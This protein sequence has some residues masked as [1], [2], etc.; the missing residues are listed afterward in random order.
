MNTMP[1]EPDSF[2]SDIRK[3]LDEV[4][5]ISDA[6]GRLPDQIAEIPKDSFR[7]FT[8][9][10]D[11]F[12]KTHAIR[13]RLETVLTDSEDVI[14]GVLDVLEKAGQDAINWIGNESKVNAFRNNLQTFFDQ[15]FEVPVNAGRL[16]LPALV[17]DLIELPIALDKLALPFEQSIANDIIRALPAELLYLIHLGVEHAGDWYELPGRLNKQLQTLSTMATVAGSAAP[18]SG[19]D[20]NKRA[21]IGVSSASVFCKLIADLLDGAQGFTSRDSSVGIDIL[22]EGL[23]GTISAN[24]LFSLLQVFKVIFVVLTD[25]FNYVLTVLAAVA[26]D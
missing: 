5:R 17:D 21:L 1:T 12:G 26:L 7:L 22:G 11:A 18:E 16:N 10:R 4:K 14:G 19:S 3:V 15:L 23:S 20:A 8:D 6:V 2:I 13:A 25:I 24:P 9:V